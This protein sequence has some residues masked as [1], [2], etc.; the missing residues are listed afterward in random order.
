[1]FL[2]CRYVMP[3]QM[4][5]SKGASVGRMMSPDEPYIKLFAS[6]KKSPRLLSHNSYKQWRAV[7]NWGSRLWW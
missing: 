1:M 7:A 3:R 5:M 6:S 4:S 2:E